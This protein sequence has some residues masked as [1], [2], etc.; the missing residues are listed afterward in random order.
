MGL[1]SWLSEKASYEINKRKLYDQYKREA[2]EANIEKRAKEDARLEF[3]AQTKRKRESL[4]P[5]KS[6][7]SSLVGNARS[8]DFGGM[9]LGLGTTERT[10]Y[11][12]VSKKPKRKS[13]TRIIYREREKIGGGLPNLGF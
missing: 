7:L 5:G 13:K 6:M 12:V 9:D 4:K 8:M 11:K 10:R 1:K 3:E 2:E